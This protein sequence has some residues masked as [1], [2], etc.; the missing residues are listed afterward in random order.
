MSSLLR[1]PLV[2]KAVAALAAKE[3][4]ERVQEARRPRRSFL[5]R[6]A[7]K[8]TL[9]ALAGAGVYVWQQQR[10]AQGLQSQWGGTPAHEPA[11]EPG[12]RLDAP[13]RAPEE[14]TETST[15]PSPAGR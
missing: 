6:H 15:E 1:Q 12:E 5:R 11:I 7:G 8:I 9:L 2:R 14:A 13:L 3:V 10:S 4:I